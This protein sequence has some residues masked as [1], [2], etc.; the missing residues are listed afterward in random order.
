MDN[1]DPDKKK[2][3]IEATAESFGRD[4][5]EAKALSVVDNADDDVETLFNKGRRTEDSPAFQAI[6]GNTFPVEN[7]SKDAI[8]PA[9]EVKDVYDD[10]IA[11]VK[12]HRDAGTLYDE[13]GKILDQVLSDLAK[14]GYWGVLIDKEYGGAGSS[15]ADFSRFIT[16]M[17]TVEPTI[18]G[19]ASVHGCI[20]AVDPVTYFGNEEQKEKYLPLLAS[21]KRLSAFALTEPGAGSDLT[22]IK[23]TA[24]LEGDHYTV[25]GK[26]LFITNAGVGRTVG[27]V[28]MIEGKQSVL[29]ADL[30]DQE[31]ETFKVN[32]YGIWALAHARNVGLEFNNFKVPKENLLVG[33]GLMIAYH[34]LN[35]GRVALCSN[36]AGVMR[37]MTANMLPW[38]KF[39]VT[40]TK[41]IAERELV[42]KRIGEL[43][44]L[45]VGCDAISEWC[46]GLLDEGYRGEMECIIAK[47]FGSE[48]LKE[49][50]I[51]YFMKTHGGRSFLHG[52]M[53]GDNVHDFLAPCIYEGEGEML[54]MAFF[55]AVSKV[56]GE[57][58]FRPISDKVGKLRAKGIVKNFNPANPLHAV[59]LLKEFTTYGFWLIGSK[60]QPKTTGDLSALKGPLKKHGQNAIK[61][62]Q[63]SGGIASAAMVKHQVALI[64]RQCRM[65][66]MSE[67]IQD[68]LVIAASCFYA[69]RS[70][71][72]IV[73]E[74]AAVLAEKLEMKI[75]GKKP[76]D[77]YYRKATKLGK[78]ILDGEWKEI[79]KIDA[80]EIRM[81]Y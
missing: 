43:A 28:C 35:K 60:L 70:K 39:R 72:P 67:N 52:H 21:G 24:T 57:T 31:D 7:F 1:P 41:Q 76:T 23:T 46:A 36:A 16:R 22:A 64:D 42:Q 81:R 47:R 68:Y 29:I 50:A 18:A 74:A 54:S 69:S 59:F 66:T 34:G 56:H 5:N 55:K 19:L 44:G 51:E 80:E 38:A 62:L 63:K 26:K 71:D 48:S 30:P 40:Y 33:K 13:N 58:Y 53:F 15:F 78:R 8:T 25:N 73:Q 77:R 79:E 65:A 75:T 14:A 4:I 27:L 11:V 37:A 3:I 2:S 6:W 12:A 10:C 9:P 17:A 20:G 49:A 32:H 45:I 61:Q